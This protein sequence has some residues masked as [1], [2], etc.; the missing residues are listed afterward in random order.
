M[1]KPLGRIE[2]IAASGRNQIPGAIPL[3]RARTLSVTVRMT[4]GAS[5]DADATIE[6]YYSPDGE[7]WDTLTYATQAV[8]FTVSTTVQKTVIIDPPEH[9]HI[10][11]KV[12]N[13]S[14]ADTITDVIAWYSIQSYAA[15]DAQS[16]GLIDTADVYD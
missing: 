12:L 13:G 11:I 7:N 9:G 16:R 6:V 4:F 1:Q 10:C 2:T 15:T 8:A 5:I 3:I 14:D